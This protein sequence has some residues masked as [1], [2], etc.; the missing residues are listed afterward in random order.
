[1]AKTTGVSKPKRRVGNK[2]KRSNYDLSTSESPRAMIKKP[3]FWG[4]KAVTNVQE[5]ARVRAKERSQRALNKA[6]R[7]INEKK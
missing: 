5:L 2:S 3:K 7:N 1:M 4:N 6:L